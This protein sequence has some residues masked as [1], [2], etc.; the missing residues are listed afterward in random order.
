MEQSDHEYLVE[1][2]DADSVFLARKYFGGLDGA[3]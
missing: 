3:E 2:L 1:L